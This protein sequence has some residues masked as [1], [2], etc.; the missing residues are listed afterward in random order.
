MKTNNLY[1]EIMKR[2]LSPRANGQS[3]EQYIKRGPEHVE[4]DIEDEITSLNKTK[5]ADFSRAYK[6][7]SFYRNKGYEH[8]LAWDKCGCH[9]LPL[10][11]QLQLRQKIK[12]IESN[13]KANTIS[14]IKYASSIFD[15]SAA[16]K[17]TALKSAGIEQ[18]IIDDVLFDNADGYHVVVQTDNIDDFLNEVSS[19]EIV[20]LANKK[21]SENKYEIVIEKPIISHVFANSFSNR[22]ICIIGF[23]SE[24]RKEVCARLANFYDL[25]LLTPEDILRKAVEIGAFDDI[26][27]EENKKRLA[28]IP[29]EIINFA[30]NVVQNH[31]E[32]FV[33]EGFPISKENLLSLDIDVI[34]FLD[35]DL[36]KIVKCQR[37]RRWCPVCE[38]LYHLKY[39]PPLHDPSVCDRCGSKII[40]R[41]EDEEMYIKDK[42]YS[43]KSSFNDLMKELKKMENFLMLIDNEDVEELAIQIHRFIKKYRDKKNT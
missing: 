16:D 26:D 33:L 3:V 30:F 5:V 36:E 9:V 12:E 41:P 20:V 14:D 1:I 23:P 11:L 25:E 4:I 32:G 40:I 29:L 43:W 38:R 27:F 28:E 35:S 37:D 13:R 34:V 8:A 42:Y 31:L 2:A 21:I 15:S 6:C 22:R 10:E 17:L 18:D 39:R 19:E 24:T 7:Y